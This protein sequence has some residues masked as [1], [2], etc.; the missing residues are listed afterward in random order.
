MGKSRKSPFW[1]PSNS[2]KSIMRGLKDTSHCFEA[3]IVRKQNFITGKRPKVPVWEVPKSRFWPVWTSTF[4]MRFCPISAQ[5]PY[6]VNK[7]HLPRPKSVFERLI[8][9]SWPRNAIFSGRAKTSFLKSHGHTYGQDRFWPKSAFLRG[10]A[11]VEFFRTSPNRPKLYMSLK[12]L[13]STT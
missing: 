9:P 6:S 5:K 2:A 7:T 4:K 12:E 8:G 13:D 11:K 1:N 3:T 10:S